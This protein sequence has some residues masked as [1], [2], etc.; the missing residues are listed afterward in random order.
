MKAEHRGDGATDAAFEGQ[1]LVGAPKALEVDRLR[2]DGRGGGQGGGGVEGILLRQTVEVVGLQS[3]TNGGIRDKQVAQQVHRNLCT[4]V[5]VERLSKAVP[6]GL[7]RVNGHAKSCTCREGATTGR[8]AGFERHHGLVRSRRGVKTIAVELHVQIQLSF[9]RAEELCAHGLQACAA[10]SGIAVAAQPAER[11][12][13]GVVERG[14]VLVVA[15]EVG[16]NSGPRPDHRRRIHRREGRV[17]SQRVKAVQKLL[18][19]TRGGIHRD[20]LFANETGGPGIEAVVVQPSCHQ[21]GGTVGGRVVK[22]RAPAAIAGTQVRVAG[23]E[24]GGATRADGAPNVAAV[25]P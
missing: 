24:Q 10:L 2:I 5:Q 19:A 11:H 1:A 25:Q 9:P 22:G 6:G 17:H 16:L 14:A 12:V 15:F 3:A 7:V 8:D 23:V 20:L 21:R 4:G 18:A 13:G